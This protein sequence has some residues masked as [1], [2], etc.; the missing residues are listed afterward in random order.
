VVT[1]VTNLKSAIFDEYFKTKRYANNITNHSR[2]RVGRRC[3]R[4]A[5]AEGQTARFQNYKTWVKTGLK[6]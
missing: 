1:L 2:V 3:I 4:D 6:S 5:A